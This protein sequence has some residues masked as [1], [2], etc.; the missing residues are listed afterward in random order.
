MTNQNKAI[1]ISHNADPDG[2]VSAAFMADSKDF[3]RL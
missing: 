3:L 1:I 2:F